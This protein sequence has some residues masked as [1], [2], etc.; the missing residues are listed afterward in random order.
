MAIYGIV[1]EYNPFHNG[2]KYQ[3]DKIRECSD[4]SGIIAVMSG[5]FVQRG[6]AAIMPKCERV[7]AA[8]Q[9]EVD[10]V[11][12]LPVPFATA[13][14]EKFAFAAIYIL[15]SFGMTDKL[16]FGSECGETDSLISAAEA[17]MSVNVD[18]LI[19]AELKSGV[20]YPTAR[21]RAVKQ[22][23]GAEI[24][25]ILN[26]P[27]NILAVEYIKAIKKLNSPIVPTTVKRAG[28][29]HDSKIIAN[30]I[31]SA[32]AVREIINKNSGISEFVPKNALEIYKSALNCGSAPSSMKRLETA[33]LASLRMKTS[34]DF[35]NIPDV[36]EGI[37]N[38][39]LSAAKTA[40]TLTQ[41]YDLAKTKRYTHS[42]IRRIVICSYL[43]ITRDYLSQNPPYIRVLGFNSNGRA[44]LREAKKKSQLPIVMSA[45]DIKKLGKP[46]ID[47][48]EL[49]CRTTDVYNLSLP[50]IR[51]CGTEMTENV[52]IFE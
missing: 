7:S 24:Y 36:S 4:C 48:F 44:I 28:A 46:A 15:N 18:E 12:E 11:L 38:R 25:E 21:A 41:L 40:S 29:A 31:I 19:K 34:T 30:N 2:H 51:R 13:T 16:S 10:L 20:S 39:I 17:V 14:A 50:E 9:N 49:E 26:E 45:S 1:A 3:L 23:C 5:N 47:F 32:S 52:L 35:N 6:E 37:E 42:R 33:I 8:L 27:N 22:Y 43:G